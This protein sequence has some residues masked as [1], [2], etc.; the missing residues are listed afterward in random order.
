MS[1]IVDP[2]ITS[3]PGPRPLALWTPIIG[4]MVAS[5]A[6]LEAAYALVGPACRRDTTWFVH[7]VPAVMLIAT[8]LM[9]VTALRVWREHGRDW[10]TQTGGMDTRTRFLAIMGLMSGASGALIIA[11]QWAAIFFHD[12]C[13]LA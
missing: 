10:E 5:L 12:P 9:T 6:T 2:V 4:P 13:A 1:E 11:A 8:V 7:L 3:V